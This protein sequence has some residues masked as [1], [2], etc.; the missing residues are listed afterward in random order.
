[1]S[2]DTR[3][4]QLATRI[5]DLTATDPQFAAAIPSDTVTASVD[6]P[7]LLLPEIVQRVLEGYAE[8]PALGERALEF[9]ADPATG[10]TTARLLPRFD[11]ISYGQV[12]DRVRALAA[13]LHASGVAAGDRVA[14]LGFTSADY[15]VIDT[16]L[17]QIGAVSVPLQTS[18]S[19]EALAPIVTETEPRVIA[20]SVDHLADAVELALTAHAPAQ[21]VVFDHH[22]EID[23]HRDAVAS[24]AERI[25]AAGASIAV[26]TLAGLL[27]RGSNLPAPE[28]PKADGSDPL[29]LLIYTSGSREIVKSCGSRVVRRPRTLGCRAMVPG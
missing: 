19:P 28:A 13:A 23:D 7:G 20:A 10:R 27:D 17:G 26:D 12:W 22:P 5:A 1:M 4:E 29:A 14:I 6:V 24:A 15:T 11:T 9:V 21:L 2:F 16:A 25:A 3:D 18:S 8:R